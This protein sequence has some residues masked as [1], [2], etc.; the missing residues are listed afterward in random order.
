VGIARWG[1]GV[2]QLEVAPYLCQACGGLSLVWL[3]TG[4]LM[5]L[6]SE[7]EALLAEHNP[8][9]WEAIEAARA[10]STPTSREEPP[11]PT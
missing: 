10:A 7:H 5:G 3:E 11:C 9:L 8:A 4:R 6:G 2:Q 1:D